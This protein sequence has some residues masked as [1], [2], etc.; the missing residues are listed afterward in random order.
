MGGAI[1]ENIK[2][3]GGKVPDE[4][5]CKVLMRGK[6]DVGRKEFD[7]RKSWEGEREEANS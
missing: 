7:L 3:A 5:R 6:G 4:I 1:E 2:K